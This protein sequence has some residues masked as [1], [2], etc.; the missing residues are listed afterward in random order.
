[1]GAAFQIADDLLDVEGT[2]EAMGKSVGKDQDA[3]KA[4]L[5]VRPGCG[6]GRQVL[7]T[8]VEEAAG[9]LAPRVRGDMLA[10]A[11]RFVA[12]RQN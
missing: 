12:E 4:T 8:L 1:M 3:G 5:C 11:A 10:A 7:G 9:A 6:G 2:T